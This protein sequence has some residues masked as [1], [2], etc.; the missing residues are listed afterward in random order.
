MFG[1]GVLVLH[2]NVVD[3]NDQPNGL[4]VEEVGLVGRNLG[5]VLFI[6]QHVHKGLRVTGPVL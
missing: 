3:A 5:L 1:D 4:G 2:D 6:R